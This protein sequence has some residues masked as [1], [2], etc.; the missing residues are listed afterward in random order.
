[1]QGQSIAAKAFRV[2]GLAD[3]LYAQDIAFEVS[4]AKLA[5]ALV[6]LQVTGT[7]IAAKVPVNTSPIHSECEPHL[8]HPRFAVPG[9]VTVVWTKL[10]ERPK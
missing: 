5:L 4:P 3:F 6:V 10:E 1:M 9:L 7:A 2:G 8:P